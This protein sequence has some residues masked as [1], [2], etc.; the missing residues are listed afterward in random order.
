MPNLVGAL[1]DAKYRI[2]RE[3]GR[4]T[5]GTVYA[6]RNESTG[7]RVAVK[8]LSRVGEDVAAARLRRE[9]AVLLRIPKHPHVVEVLDGGERAGVPYLVM[10]LVPGGSLA[11]A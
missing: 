4:G 6:A 9:L 1:L 8:V 5:Y 7:L 3:L 11:A 10:E 2:E